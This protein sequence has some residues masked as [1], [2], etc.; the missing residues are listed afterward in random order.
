MWLSSVLVGPSLFCLTSLGNH[1]TIKINKPISLFA[2]KKSDQ[3]PKLKPETRAVRREQIL[4]AA[5]TCFVRTG[6]HKTTMDNVVQE[7]GLSK[8]SIYSHFESKKE[9]FL[10]L[11]DKM[12]ADT[13]LLPVLSAEGPTGGEKLETA[14][15][16]ATAFIG[17]DA[18]QEYAALVLEVWAQN[19]QDAEVN[20]AAVYL[21]DQLR[22]PFIQLFEEGM[23]AGE[24]KPVN[25]AAMANLFIGAFDGLMVQAMIE[26]TAV[27]WNATVQ[28]IHDTLLAAL[29]MDTIK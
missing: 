29:M 12:I 5:L 16:L 1:I 26:E 2:I 9:I 21:Y 7:A 8:G 17:S 28:T 10:A 4:Q 3:M 19:R 20:Q 13:G 14:L 18:Y 6:Y 11:L 23:A 25:A 24:F 15:T 27:D 22:R